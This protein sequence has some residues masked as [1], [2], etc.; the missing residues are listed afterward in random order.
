MTVDTKVQYARMG[1]RL[2]DHVKNGTTDWAADT[3]EVP[4]SSYTDPDQWQREM[5]Q[6]FKSQPILVGISQEIPEAGDFKTLN[7]LGIPLLLTRQK[8]G[9]AKV[10]LN[11]CTHR[12]MQLMAEPCGNQKLFSCPYHGWT[13]KADGSLRAV[14]DAPKQ[15]GA[16]FLNDDHT[17][18]GSQFD[19]V[20]VCRSYCCKRSPAQPKYCLCAV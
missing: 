9:S 18:R 7:M 3:M 10:L 8:D 19:A 6:I 13:F 20:C 5:D 1:A 17:F 16:T 14:A 4:S 15:P 12:G 2:I 11:V